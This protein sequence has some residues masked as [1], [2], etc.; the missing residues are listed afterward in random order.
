MATLSIA[1]IA[2]NEADV[3]GKALQSVAWADQIVVIDCSSNDA[4]PEIA[5]KAGAEV[6][7][8]SNLKN[9][10]IN[11]NISI[12]RC[13]SDWVLVFDADEIIPYD[14]AGEIRAVINDAD[15]DGYWIKRKNFTL[16]RWLKHASSYPD[17]QLRLFRNGKGRFPADHIHERIQIDGSIGRL[18]LPFDHHPFRCLD[19]MMRK[20]NRDV[21]FESQYMYDKGVKDNITTI[22]PRVLIQPFFRFFRRYILKGGFLDG[23]PGLAMAFLDV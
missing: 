7:N 10:N 8:E 4:T 16:G 21:V 9:L 15:H 13:T 3:I 2:Y 19:D 20:L 17:R 11:K 12:D 1:M 14:L 5:R 23:I 18:S 22:L 6:F